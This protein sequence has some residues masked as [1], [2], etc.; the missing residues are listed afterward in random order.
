M[1]F[2]SRGSKTLTFYVCVDQFKVG[3][4][5]SNEKLEAQKELVNEMSYRMH[6]D[7]SV[8]R[9]GKILFGDDEGQRTLNAIRPQGKV[10]VDDW[11]CLK[12]MVSRRFEVKIKDS[13][14]LM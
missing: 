10:L 8:T 12:S 2:K 7:E 11:S 1:L 3:K 14:D 4:E 6:L 9:I 13:F 5:G